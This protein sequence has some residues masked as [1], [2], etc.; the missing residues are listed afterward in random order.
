MDRA[1]KLYMAVECTGKIF[2]FN[3]EPQE[4]KEF[5]YNGSE[6]NDHDNYPVWCVRKILYENGPFQEYTRDSIDYG[7]QIPQVMVKEF[8]GYV[9]EYT[10]E[11]ICISF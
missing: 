6:L 10:G 11:P 9:P 8:L 4:Y 1:I 7:V 3:E 5:T 2:V